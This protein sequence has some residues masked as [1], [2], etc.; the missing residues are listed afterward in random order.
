M[1]ALCF[2]TQQHRECRNVQNVGPPGVRMA[3]D[4]GTN[5][6]G[7]HLKREALSNDAAEQADALNDLSH[8]KM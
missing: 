1:V 7:M 5:E 2:L 4:K 3:L 8:L 6:S